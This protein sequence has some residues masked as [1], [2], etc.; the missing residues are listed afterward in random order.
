[1]PTSATHHTSLNISL[2]VE[3]VSAGYG[4]D[5]P[6]LEGLTLTVGGPGLVL[7]EGENG[8]GKSTLVE[9]ISG[10]LVPRSGSVRVCGL[11]PASPDASTVRRICRTEPALYPVMTA[12]DHL[13]F[14][15]RWAGTDPAVGAARAVRYGLG[16]WLD[17]PAGSLSTGNRRKLWLVMCTQGDVGL[18]MLDEPFNGLD[19]EGITLLTEELAAWATTRIVLLVAHR[20]P[21][22][23]RPHRRVQLGRPA[24]ADETRAPV[25]S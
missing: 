22:A 11:D 25:H 10:Y 9:V 24:A 1:M 12:R 2:T 7:V 4:L 13:V 8:T 3:N 14:A 6:V 17:T 23:L 5:A 20:P 19:A 18:V 16:P 21:A 15:S